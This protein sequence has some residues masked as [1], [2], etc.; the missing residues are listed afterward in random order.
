[1]KPFNPLAL[2]FPSGGRSKPIPVIVEVDPGCVMWDVFVIVKV[3]VLVCELNSH[4][5]VA[6][7]NAPLSTPT[8]LIVSAFADVAPKRIKAHTLRQRFRRV[9]IL[10]IANLLV[11]E[12]V[13]FG[14]EKGAALP[15]KPMPPLHRYSRSDFRRISCKINLNFTQTFQNSD[16]DSRLQTLLLEFVY[17]I[18]PVAERYLALTTLVLP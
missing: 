4:T 2:A 13:L 9:L 14:I 15:A 17:C 8:M 16:C 18:G 1:V 10:G 12:Q 5:T 7:E 11:S 6:V 3:K